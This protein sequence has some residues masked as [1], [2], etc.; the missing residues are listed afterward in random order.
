MQHDQVSPH[1][2]VVAGHLSG[3]RIDDPQ[4]QMIIERM[5]QWDGNLS[6]QSPE[7]AIYELFFRRVVRL[8]VDHH[9]GD[10]G[11][12][13]AGKGPTPVLAEGSLF[14]E[15]AYE[16]LEKILSEPDSKWW[17]IGAGVNRDDLMK[18]AL[19]QTTEELK[20]TQ[21]PSIN[22]WQWGKLHKLT[23][24]HTLGSVKPLDK[25]FNRGPY[26]VGGDSNTVWNT[27]TAYHDPSIDQLIGPPFRFIADMSDLNKCQGMLAPGQSGQPGS[28]HYDDQVEAW[29]KCGYHPMYFTREDVE[30]AAEGKLTLEPD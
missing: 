15:R 12:R 9:L 2:R 8:I 1:A 22:D 16:W 14:G 29:F 19:H 30:K 3:L 11:I 18:T 25:I 28:H 20:R 5:R 21:G 26:P 4:L 24:T 10:L 13:Y 17:E 6:L 23:F 27:A 7:A